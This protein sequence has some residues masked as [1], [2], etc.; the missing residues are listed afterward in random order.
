[1]M[2]RTWLGRSG[3]AALACALGAALAFSLAGQGCSKKPP[4]TAPAAQLPPEVVATSPPARSVHTSTET[5]IWADFDRA[6]DASTVDSK[7]VALKIDTRRLPI[8]V[9]YDAAH[10]RV[11]IVPTSELALVTTHTVE[12]QPGLKTADGDTL[13]QPYFWQFTTLGVRRPRAPYPADRVAGESP[14]VEL[15]WQGTEATA[16]AIAYDL[17]AGPDSTAVADRTLAS[18]PLT[19][20]RFLPE[21]R[22]PQDGPTFWSVRTTNLGTG[23]QLDGATWRFDP[24]PTSTPIDSV[25]VSLSNWWYGNKANLTTYSYF[26]LASRVI[27]GS[28]F[29]NFEQWNLSVV[30]PGVRLADAALVMTPTTAY[31]D[32]VARGLQ[33]FSVAATGAPCNG[34][35]RAPFNLPIADRP[36]AAAVVTSDLRL[37]LGSD[38][39]AALVESMVR[40]GTL[41]ATILRASSRIDLMASGNGASDPNAPKL[42]LYVYRPGP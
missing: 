18:V 22:W 26:C 17:Y 41:N 5:A 7:H 12:F 42:M 8:T 32:G 25:I 4:P 29:D 34:T 13:G 40:R 15:V 9:S 11:V 10:R 21:G 39:L 2:R 38:A 36:K 1:M 20:A 31:H 6:L 30:D 37:R 23:E 24:L 28:P 14:F 19:T 16:G 33:V 35:I 3:I 27:A